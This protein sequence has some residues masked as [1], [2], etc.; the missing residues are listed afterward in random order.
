VTYAYRFF[1]V[2]AVNV[3]LIVRPVSAQ[4]GLQQ[5]A[6]QLIGPDATA[7]VCSPTELVPV[8]ASLVSNFSSPAGW[9]TPLSM[10]LLDDC[11]GAVA[12]GQVTAAFSNETLRWH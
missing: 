9:P 3:A 6:G 8:Q 10:Q 4:Q 12:N 7:A 1:G 11:A 5:T 2:R